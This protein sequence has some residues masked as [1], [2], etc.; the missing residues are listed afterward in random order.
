MTRIVSFSVLS[1]VFL[2]AVIGGI[3]DSAADVAR[4]YDFI[5]VG[6]KRRLYT[7]FQIH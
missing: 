6:G 7:S 2:D 5:V 4:A 1:V 3:V